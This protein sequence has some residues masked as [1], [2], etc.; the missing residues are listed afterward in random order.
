MNG[1]RGWVHWFG[2]AQW[3]EKGMPH[4][5]SVSVVISALRSV[6]VVIERSECMKGS[7]V[8]CRSKWGILLKW[9]CS[10]HACFFS[11]VLHAS[12]SWVHY[13]D[14]FII[15]SV[16]SRCEAIGLM[17]WVG[18]S[19]CVTIESI[20]HVC[21]ITNGPSDISPLTNIG[22]QWFCSA[23]ESFDRVLLWGTVGV[24]WQTSGDL[25]RCI[26]S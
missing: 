22:N 25:E 1:E 17:W 13:Y 3:T 5:S 11:G 15:V 16:E 9:R 12:V 21:I 7:E 26:G 10:S 14:D 2:Y 20:C 19:V 24:V 6:L 18:I 23:R 4:I 8:C